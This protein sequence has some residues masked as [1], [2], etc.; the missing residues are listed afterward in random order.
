MTDIDPHA[1]AHPW[2]PSWLVVLTII[3][4]WILVAGFLFATARQAGWTLGWTYFG[5][6]AAGS[7]ISKLCLLIWN[8][9]LFRRRQHIGQGAKTCDKVWLAVFIANVIAL[10]IVAVSSFDT[11]PADLS[12]PTTAQLIGL[13]LLISGWSLFTLC[14]VV[15]PFFETAVRIQGN[16]G[17]HVVDTG[18]YTFIRHPGYLGLISAIG[19]ATPLML[20]SPWIIFL[21]LMA[22]LLIVIRTAY[23]DRTLKA[24]LPGYRDYTRRVRFR[25]IPGI[26]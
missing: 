20:S 11:L 12:S 2:R 9:D 21:S 16:V 15:N 24:E 5:V 25:L 23:E 14:S 22:L 26:W 13:A 8:P 7:G 1:E 3:A 4:M 19:L 18:P 10:W 6:S 17:H